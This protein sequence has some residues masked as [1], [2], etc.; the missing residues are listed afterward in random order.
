M[1]QFLLMIGVVA[2]VGGCGGKTKICPECKENVKAEAR[3]CVHCYYNIAAHEAAIVAAKA[4][5]IRAAE[6]ERRAEAKRKA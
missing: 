4:T 2:M 6:A 5:A 1:K 3:K